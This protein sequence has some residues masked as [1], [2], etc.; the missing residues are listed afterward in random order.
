[1]HIWS[2]LRQA[3]PELNRR[4]AELI[5]RPFDILERLPAWTDAGRSFDGIEYT[6]NRREC[7]DGRIEVVLQAYRPGRRILFLKFGEMLARGF[8]ASPGGS[9]E[10]MP[11]SAL[12][13]YM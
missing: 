10:R 3:E 8:W 4:L 13:D 7:P 2:S 1:M 12:Y 6:L 9:R 5:E 11:E